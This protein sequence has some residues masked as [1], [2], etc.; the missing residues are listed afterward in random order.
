MHGNTHFLVAAS[1]AGAA[2]GRLLTTICRAHILTTSTTSSRAVAGLC[3]AGYEYGSTRDALV[4]I[5]VLV[6]EELVDAFS[7]IVPPA[8]AQEVG[9][10]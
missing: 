6:N 7:R 3:L 4:K 9:R 5:D 10:R 2:S 8:Q 1:A